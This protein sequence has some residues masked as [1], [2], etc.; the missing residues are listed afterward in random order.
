[1]AKARK[2]GKNSKKKPIGQYD[3]KGKKRINDPLDE[4]PD[5]VSASC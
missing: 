2:I 1:M 3:H 4:S 5:I